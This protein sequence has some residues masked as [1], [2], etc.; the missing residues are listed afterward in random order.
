MV[1]RSGLWTTAREERIHALDAGLV[2]TICEFCAAVVVKTDITG[3]AAVLVVVNDVHTFTI[4]RPARAAA[5][6]DRSAY[7][8]LAASSNHNCRAH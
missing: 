4:W 7:W 2:T 5:T 8:V 1:D 3:M 6:A